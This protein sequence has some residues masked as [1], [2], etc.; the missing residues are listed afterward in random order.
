L[1][2]LNT[3]NYASLGWVEK[4]A[5]N[6]RVPYDQLSVFWKPCSIKILGSKSRL[7]EDVFLENK[8]GLAKDHRGV[9]SRKSMS[10]PEKSPGQV[11]LGI[12]P[13]ICPKERRT[14]DV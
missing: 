5:A 13:T 2:F 14:P 1:V 4:K 7:I 9:Y 12:Y 3:S 8:A 11:T 6:S 10:A